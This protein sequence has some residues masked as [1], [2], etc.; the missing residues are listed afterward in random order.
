[1]SDIQPSAP[2]KKGRGRPFAK[3]ASGNPSGRPT[4]RVVMPTGEV[5]S[6]RELARS[7]TKEAFDVLAL[8]MRS[9][10]E[11]VAVAAAEAIL[12]RGWGKA[13]QSVTGED[14]EGPVKHK[15]TV[16]FK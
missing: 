10:D 2:K 6:L 9:D 3:G 12:S 15:I 13:P 1:M 8:S 11:R 16:S 7:F 5:V 14:G 4:E